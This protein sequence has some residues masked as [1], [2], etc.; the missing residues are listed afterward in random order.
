[1]NTLK[2]TN[3]VSTVFMTVVV[4]EDVLVMVPRWV[5]T[6]VYGGP[7]LQTSAMSWEGHRKP[8]ALNIRQLLTKKLLLQLFLFFWDDYSPGN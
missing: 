4:E 1:M 7:G 8:E 2:N 6:A 3:S 5:F